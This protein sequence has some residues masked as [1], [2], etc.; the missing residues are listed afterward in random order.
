MRSRE[1]QACARVIYRATVSGGMEASIEA[2][3]PLEAATLADAWGRFTSLYREVD[4]YSLEI[5]IREEPDQ[6]QVRL[7]CVKPPAPAE[8][9][10]GR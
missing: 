1:H 3:M 9:L 4:P 7:H 8:Q 2:S 5:E 10:H 6:R